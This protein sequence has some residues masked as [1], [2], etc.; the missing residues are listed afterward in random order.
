[1][2]CCALHAAE[3]GSIAYLS[4]ILP[5]SDTLSC[6]GQDQQ[7]HVAKAHSLCY[8]AA[9]KH[10]VLLSTMQDHATHNANCVL[11]CKWAGCCLHSAC[12]SA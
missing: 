2:P 11:A 1:M 10:L 12:L 6:Q 3:H 8:L 7:P 5:S 9:C 4:G